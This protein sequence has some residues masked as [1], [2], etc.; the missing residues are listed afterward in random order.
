[1]ILRFCQETE[2]QNY[3]CLLSVRQA[4]RIANQSAACVSVYTHTL[5]DTEPA[6]EGVAERIT[7]FFSGVSPSLLYK[8]VSSLA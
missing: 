8:T 4:R 7:A 2:H 1:M 5:S 6:C 3:I